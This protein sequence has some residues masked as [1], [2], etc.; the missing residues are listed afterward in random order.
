MGKNQNK[1]PEEVFEEY[2]DMNDNDS[3]NEDSDTSMST[4]G[5]DAS[6]DEIEHFES[7][8]VTEAESDVDEPVE[9]E[10]E[11]EDETIKAI[12][13][14]S[15]KERD[16]PPSIQCEDFITDIS[17]HPHNDLLAVAT[18]VGDV[19]LYKYSNDEN[20]LENTLELH[21]KAC[22]DVEFSLDGKILFS[23]SKDKSIMLSD[24]E[25]G[26]LVKFYEDSHDVPVYCLTVI[27]ENLFATGDDDGTIK[28]WDLREK[29][30]KQI[31]KT[32]K[33]E[34]YISDLVTNDSKKYLVGSSGDGS[35]ISIN[36]EQRCVH[37]QSEE[38]DEELTSMG[39]FRS[40][41]KLVASSSK[42]R[43]F[44]YNWD[45][46]GLHSDIFPGPKTSINALMPITE[47]IVVTACEDGNLRASH[48]FPHRHLGIVGQHNMPVENVDICNSGQFLASSSHNN[49]IRF[50]NIQYFEDFEKMDQK[51]K[52]HNKKKELKNNLPSSNV[53][54]AS[55]FFSGLV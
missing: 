41:T 36:L 19:L 52:K 46:F 55:D 49:D 34:D 39:I 32:R 8:A 14:E 44:V 20:T 17:F 48:L 47:N 37:M 40:E 15:Q 10:E 54:N 28:L 9:A 24:V 51:H 31:Y 38:Y 50:W 53:K 23:T 25:T 12:R 3:D 13:L 2:S 21:T 7:S 27:D 30:D 6:D 18:I 29:S 45:E 16:H 26:K 43:L 5:S 1:K 35:I 22:R 4:S 11:E 42:G 33:N